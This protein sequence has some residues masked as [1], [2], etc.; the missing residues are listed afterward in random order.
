MPMTVLIMLLC[1]QA[2][3]RSWAFHDFIVWLSVAGVFFVAKERKAGVSLSWL[4]LM[5]SRFESP[6]LNSLSIYSFTFG[7]RIFC[8]CETKTISGRIT[9]GY[10]GKRRVGGRVPA[11]DVRSSSGCGLWLVL[12][13]GRRLKKV[14]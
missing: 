10:S 5:S 2:P 7:F 14:A 4:F 12:P 3:A 13:A 6:I 11:H 1:V 8:D 9:W